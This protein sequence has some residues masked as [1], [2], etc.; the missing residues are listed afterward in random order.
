MNIRP[1]HT[2]ADLY[3]LP[4]GTVFRDEGVVADRGFGAGVGRRVFMR[5][6]MERCEMLI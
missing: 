5:T 2:L 4:Q 3:S 6:G 1:Q